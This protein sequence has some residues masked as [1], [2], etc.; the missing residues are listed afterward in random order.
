MKKMKK[1]VSLLLCMLLLCMSL[2]ACGNGSEGGKDSSGKANE[3]EVEITWW[4]SYSTAYTVY[5]D[6]LIEKFNELHEGEYHVTQ[7]YNGD[8]DQLRT[9][10]ATT[11][12][13]ELPNLI[14]GTPMATAYFAEQDNIIP[15]QKFIDEDKDDW[16]N[17]LYDTVKEAYSTAEGKM[18]GFPL[19]IS[20]PGYYVN[21]EMLKKAGYSVEDITSYEKIANIATEISKKNIAQYGISHYTTGY[22]LADAL[23]LQGVHFYDNDNGHAGNPTKSLI[24]EGATYEALKK[25]LQAFA[26]LYENNVAYNYNG[27]LKAEIIPSFVQGDI[28]MVGATS[29]YTN[30][31]VDLEPEFEWRFVSTLPVDDNAAFKGTAMVEGHGLYIVDNGNEKAAQGAYE[32]L[33]F[34]AQ[35]D[36]QAYWCVNT[37]YIP[38]TEEG[39]TNAEYQEW[40]KKNFPDSIEMKEQFLNPPEG[41]KA[42][43][44]YLISAV[45]DVGYICKDYMFTE[46]TRDID[47]VI[48][49][50]YDSMQ[51]AIDIDALRK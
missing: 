42:P 2:S 15:V 13:E 23:T 11:K 35:S 22:D 41:L 3:G 47:E 39:Y 14:I 9:N 44:S 26:S 43:Y 17:K 24:K 28:A 50:A 32:F 18:I 38:Y 45:Q 16:T 20:C 31:I 12:K 34:M 1:V 6:E 29:S 7:L 51:E 30:I 49:W 33:K 25:Y 10:V 19:G 27:D 4:V 48:G 46:P 36:N 8:D 37:G 40:M 5:F 21:V